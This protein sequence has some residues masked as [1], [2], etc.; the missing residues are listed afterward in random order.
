M[1][2]SVLAVRSGWRWSLLALA[3]FG[4]MLGLV[5]ARLLHW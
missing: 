4:V 5:L 2:A 1:P 3:A